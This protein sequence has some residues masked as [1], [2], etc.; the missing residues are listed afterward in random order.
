MYDIGA[1]SSLPTSPITVLGLL[2]K[3]EDYEQ[4]FCVGGKMHFRISGTSN[5]LAV[6]KVSTNM[7]TTAKKSIQ[8]N[9]PESLRQQKIGV[10]TKTA[11]D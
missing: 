11:S 8:S 7:D 9:Q 2:G 1:H 10:F 6:L 4:F 3:K 5:I